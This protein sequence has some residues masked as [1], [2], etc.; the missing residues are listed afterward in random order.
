MNPDLIWSQCHSKTWTSY[1]MLSIKSTPR[2]DATHA[3][4]ER[5]VRHE[6]EPSLK[7]IYQREKVAIKQTRK[8]TFVAEK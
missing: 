5:K 2:S 3:G 6:Q 4:A 8:H 7:I 1:R